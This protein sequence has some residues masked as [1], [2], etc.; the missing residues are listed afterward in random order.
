MGILRENRRISVRWTHTKWVLWKVLLLQICTPLIGTL[1]CFDWQ[2]S[3][4][5]ESQSELFFFFFFFFFFSLLLFKKSKI[6][7]N[8][9]IGRWS[10]TFFILISGV[11]V[12]YFVIYQLGCGGWTSL[13][14]LLVFVTCFWPRLIVAVGIVVQVHFV[15]GFNGLRQ[16]VLQRR[17][18]RAHGRSPESVRNKTEVGQTALNS[19]LENGLRTW[20]PQGRAVLWEQVRELFADLSRRRHNVG[21]VSGWS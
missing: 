2:K 8:V 9:K 19:G 4:V 13:S 16:I 14:V 6:F 1:L 3:L 11:F 10:V 5:R 17:E 20:I 18:G 15:H 21:C 7:Q 12:L